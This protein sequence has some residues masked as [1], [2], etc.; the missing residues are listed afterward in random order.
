MSQSDHSSEAYQAA[1]AQGF[2]GTESEFNDLVINSEYVEFPIAAEADSAT[3][4]FSQ[5]TDTI[6]LIWAVGT[7]GIA[8]LLAHALFFA[9]NRWIGFD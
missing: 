4:Y 6:P 7:L 1:V 2:V 8:T 3:V 9:W 5:P